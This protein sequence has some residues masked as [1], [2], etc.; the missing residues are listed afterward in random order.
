MKNYVLILICVLIALQI[1]AQTIPF[2]AHYAVTTGCIKPNNQTQAQLDA[3]VQSFYTAWKQAYLKAGCVAGQYY[4]EYINGTN[5]C[6]SE[7]QGYGM[8]ITAH[9]AGYDALAQTYFDGL[10]KWYKTHPSTINAALMNWQQGTGCVSNGNDAA[11]DGDLDIA[12]AL[13]LAHRQ[14]GSAGT[15]NYLT[16][17]TTIINAIKTAELYPTANT[18]A[19]GD[20]APT[21]PKYNDDTRPSDFMY[22]HFVSFNAFT[23]D[24]IWNTVN[25]NCYNLIN[26]IQTNYSSAT[27]LIP[28]FI[29]DVDGTPHPAVSSATAIYLE[30]ANDGQFYYNACRVPWHL[31]TSYLINGDIR[32]KNA[33]DKINTWI[34]THTTNTVA[35]IRAGYKLSGANI[36]GNNYQDIAFIA[37][38]GVAACV[39]TTN[40][41]W[42]NDLWTY[43][44]NEPIAGNDYYQNTIKMLCMLSISQNYFPPQ[45]A[46]TTV[47]TTV[48]ENNG[49]KIY[50]NPVQNELYINVLNAQVI[51]LNMYGNVVKSIPN[52][53]STINVADLANGVY[54]VIIT[55]PNNTAIK[56]LVKQ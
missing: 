4:V 48:S 14:W 3:S 2:P 38:L 21:D 34:K 39:S 8:V 1:K 19:L 42:L 54:T 55:T 10:Y 5:I 44:I 27:G 13:L 7:G 31:G 52:N 6:V 20:W 26:T 18:V 56:R 24:T 37:P 17:A 43:I 47:N 45:L 12:Y 16:E 32:A 41:A 40:Q 46:T 11:T 51:L 29:E 33:S 28:D 30:D 49:I 15:I 50:P 23:N 9:M 35:N 53:T 25:N 36:T 22:D